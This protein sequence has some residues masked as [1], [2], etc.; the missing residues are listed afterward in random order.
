MT[1]KTM[2]FALRHSDRCA[3]LVMISAKSQTPPPITPLQAL[4]FKS[5]F[6]SD[7]LFWLIT[8]NMKP[9]FLSMMG[10]SIEVQ[11]QA[12]AR[13]RQL[14]SDFLGSMHPISLRR[15]GIY[16][17]MATLAALPDDV[18][19]LEQISVPTLV[20]HAVDDGLQSYSHGVNTATRVPDAEFISYRQGGHLL[21]LQLDDVRE[22]VAAFLHLRGPK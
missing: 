8:Q 5:I 21:V 22:K 4:V 20:I 12:T 7:Y 13:A 10:V 3:A 14:F 6:R 2:K 16:H 18:F 9:F 17:D 11:K 19:R 1:N 15:D